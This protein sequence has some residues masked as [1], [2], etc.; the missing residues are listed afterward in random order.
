MDE[1]DLTGKAT[2][3]LVDDV[4]DDLALINS[5]GKSCRQRREGFKNCVIGVAA[6]FDF[7]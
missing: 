7:A 2:I 3:L 6:G 5:Q 4:P 1:N